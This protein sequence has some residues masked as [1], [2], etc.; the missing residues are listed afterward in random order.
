MLF[1]IQRS[2][3]S[4]RKYEHI[5]IRKIRLLKQP[6]RFHNDFVCPVNLF[7]SGNRDRLHIDLSPA[8]NINVNPS[9][10]SNP[11]AKKMYTFKLLPP[12]FT[13]SFFSAFALL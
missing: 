6:I 9:I 13:F 1:Q 4:A 5:P 11:S 3:H 2:R 12:Y 8:H 7:L 10:S